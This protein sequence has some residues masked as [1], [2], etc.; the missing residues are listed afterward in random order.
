MADVHD[1]HAACARLLDGLFEGLAFGCGRHIPVRRT[2]AGGKVPF[3][4]VI[5]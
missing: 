5:G 3:T 1:D 4:W 2:S